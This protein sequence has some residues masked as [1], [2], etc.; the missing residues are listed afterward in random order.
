MTLAV[1]AVVSGVLDLWA[2]KGS[3][4]AGE[5]NEI[6]AVSAGVDLWSWSVIR[7]TPSSETVRSAGASAGAGMNVCAGRTAW[8][9]SVAGK[10]WGCCCA[11]AA[12]EAASRRAMT[13]RRQVG[14]DVLTNRTAPFWVGCM[15]PR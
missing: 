9:A 1:P 3:L 15:S 14:M 5:R 7:F 4:D 2:V 13:G 12:E 10:V 6:F 11:T 8:P